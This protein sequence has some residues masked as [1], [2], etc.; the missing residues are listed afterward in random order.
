MRAL[1]EYNPTCTQH[2]H[3]VGFHTCS[4]PSLCAVSALTVFLNVPLGVSR[5]DV[6]LSS[7]NMSLA[8]LSVK[9]ASHSR[10]RHLP[11]VSYATSRVEWELDHS[12]PTPRLHTNTVIQPTAAHLSPISS[13]TES[14]RR[15]AGHVGA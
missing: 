11:T 4:C 8:S 5:G 12:Q 10:P 9:C 14:P 1:L 2:H 6:A 3:S 13:H 7:L 15:V